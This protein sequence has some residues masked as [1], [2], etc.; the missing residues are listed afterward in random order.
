MV[1][2]TL[3]FTGNCSALRHYTSAN[4]P[5]LL[6]NY[7]I[8]DYLDTLH[9]FPSSISADNNDYK[10][11]GMFGLPCLSGRSICWRL[12]TERAEDN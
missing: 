10:S 12:D 4:N 1:F 5:N 8:P 6:R 3:R 7:R 9:I 2:S 11:Y